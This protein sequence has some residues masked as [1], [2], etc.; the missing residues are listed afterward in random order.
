MSTFV[1]NDEQLI[2]I[3]DKIPIKLVKVKEKAMTVQKGSVQMGTTAHLLAEMHE[4]LRQLE[5][6]IYE[7]QAIIARNNSSAGSSANSSSTN[8]NAGA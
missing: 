4:K 3:G 6:L 1:Y 5:S 2:N 8:D 7:L